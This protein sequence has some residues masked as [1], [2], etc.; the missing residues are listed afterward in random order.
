MVA[1]T[2]NL[3][4]QEARQRIMSLGSAVSSRPAWSAT[5]WNLVS[6]KTK[7][8]TAKQKKKHLEE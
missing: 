6:N 7:T 3:S 4:T 1:H 5:Y 8:Q 2:Y